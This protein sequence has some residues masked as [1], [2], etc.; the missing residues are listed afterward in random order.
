[1]GLGSIEIAVA[2]ELRGRKCP[3]GVAVGG[4]DRDRLPGHGERLPTSDVIIGTPIAFVF[5]KIS[6]RQFGIGRGEAGLA[7]DGLAKQGSGR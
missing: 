3:V 2:V 7:R 6:E 5:G 1:M 4:I